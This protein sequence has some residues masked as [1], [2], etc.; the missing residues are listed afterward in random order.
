MVILKDRKG[1]FKSFMNFLK[2]KKAFVLFMIATSI[3][4]T[5]WGYDGDTFEEVTTEG[6]TLCYTVISEDEKT[7]K[8]SG[9]IDSQ[10]STNDRPVTIPSMVNDYSVVEIG[11]RAFVSSRFSKFII[12]STVERVCSYAFENCYS[13]YSLNFS[14]GVRVVEDYAVTNCFN[15]NSISFGAD[16]DSIGKG[17]GS[18]CRYLS[19]IS[20]DSYNQ[21]YISPEWYDED[22]DEWISANCV[23]DQYENRLVVGCKSTV[24][25]SDG[26]VVTI[27]TGSFWNIPLLEDIDIP[28]GVVTIEPSAFSSCSQLKKVTIGKDLQVFG[29]YDSSTGGS[30]C[31]EP[32]MWCENLESFSISPDNEYMDS[33]DDC[34]ALISTQEN[35]LVIGWSTTVIPE[36]VE[37]ISPHAFAYCVSNNGTGLSGKVVIPDAVKTIGKDAFSNNSNITELI[38]GRSLQTIGAGAFSGLSISSVVIPENVVLIDIMAFSGCENLTEVEFECGTPTFTEGPTGEKVF[39]YCTNLKDIYYP[40][41]SYSKNSC[42]RNS[43]HVKGM[44]MHPVIKPKDVWSTYCSSA[45]L[46]VPLGITAYVVRLIAGD[47]LH[48]QEISNINKGQGLLL[49]TESP[50]ERIEVTI[51]SNEVD[52]E[53]NELYGTLSK[54]LL[55]SEDAEKSYYIQDGNTFQLV[56]TPTYLPAY[57]AYLAVPKASASSVYYFGNTSET[58]PGDVDNDTE[59]TVADVTALVN[60]ILGKDN[61]EPY[62]YNHKAADVNGD[63]AI[64]VA[65]VTALVNKILG[66]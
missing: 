35:A 62:E 54:T 18:G 1:M 37:S 10:T 29:D 58:M 16:V 20:V 63:K 24:I 47:Q 57:H 13:L 22:K 36:T 65:D 30:Y 7:C 33:R 34:N 44:K 11:E 64:S 45:S 46:N 55:P 6:E 14:D 51:S 25:P 19:N 50:G 26:T 31:S 3:P 56:S 38:M 59:V 8:V 2:R 40:A 27:A 52:V 66:R 61:G 49:H 42:V 39:E 53:I 48:L 60:I 28:N 32:G 43:N 5:T 17:I 21:H 23:I 9:Y 12:P 4:S 41:S 15:I